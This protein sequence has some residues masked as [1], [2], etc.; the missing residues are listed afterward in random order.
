MPNILILDD[1]KGNRDHMAEIFTDAG[2]SVT[3]TSSVA[4][5][6]HG[7]LKKLAQVL[8]LG[9]KCDELAA[10]DLIALVKQCN[11]KMPIILIATEFSLGLLRRLRAEGIFYHALKPVNAEDREE[12]RQA[13]R[14]AVKNLRPQLT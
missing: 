4:S 11:P 1:D 9:T 5:A 10:V 7:V 12:V 13:V 14:C 6:I 3:A 2:F 8:V